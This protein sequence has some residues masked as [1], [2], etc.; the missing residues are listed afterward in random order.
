MHHTSLCISLQLLVNP[1]LLQNEQLSFKKKS[2][3]AS[4]HLFF[5]PRD[6]SASLI[7]WRCLPLGT[8]FHIFFL[9]SI[10]IFTGLFLK[11]SLLQGKVW[12]HWVNVIPMQFW[13][14]YS[15]L[16]SSAFPLEMWRNV[17]CLP[18]H[19]N[20]EDAKSTEIPMNSFHAEIV[21]QVTIG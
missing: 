11:E 18:P 13:G 8:L 15:T 7:S 17:T 4:K 19:K 12:K 1:Q 21:E 10:H 6:V 2:R 3:P 20:S 9:F 16:C 5:Q 14:R